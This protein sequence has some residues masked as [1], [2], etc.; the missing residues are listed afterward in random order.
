MFRAATRCE[1]LK[2]TL[3]DGLSSQGHRDCDGALKLALDDK[4][5]GLA[6]Q[7]LFKLGPVDEMTHLG[8]RANVDDTGTCR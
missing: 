6:L 3:N 7:C 1:I 5:S 2:R 8:T 4:A